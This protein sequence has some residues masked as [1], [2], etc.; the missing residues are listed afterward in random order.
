AFRA[1]GVLEGGDEN[2][3]GIFTVEGSRVVLAGGDGVEDE[4]G[5]AG[6]PPA[7]R[8]ECAGGVPADV[9]IGI[10]Q[11]GEER[12]DGAMIADG[13]K[14]LR[15]GGADFRFTVLERVDERCEA[16]FVSEC[17]KPP[18]GGDAHRGILVIERLGEMRDDGT[19]LGSDHLLNRG[20]AVFWVARLQPL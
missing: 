5:V 15:G 20:F 6:W 16:A 7:E 14:R 3:D 17:A 13:T 11:R 10:L 2:L 12:L 1:G 19:G 4:L 9:V 8:L 18:G